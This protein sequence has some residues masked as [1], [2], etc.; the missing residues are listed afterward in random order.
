MAD[1]IHITT[2]SLERLMTQTLRPSTVL[3]LALFA[4]AFGSAQ[5]EELRIT[6]VRPAANNRVVV[7]GTPSASSSVN[8]EGSADF[9]NWTKLQTFAPGVSV[10]Y[11]DS[12][13]S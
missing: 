4:G 12:A 6:S 7:N 11:T 5:A 3:V 8:L 10:T 2:P 1:L 9:R 13:T